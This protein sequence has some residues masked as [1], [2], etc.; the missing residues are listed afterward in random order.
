ML[1]PD[2]PRDCPLC[3]GHEE[4]QFNFFLHCAVVFW[5]VQGFRL[6]GYVMIWE[7]WKARN[8]II[9]INFTKVVVEV[10]D[11]IKGVSWGWILMRLKEPSLFYEWCWDPNDLLMR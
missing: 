2:G 1:H 8:E 3:Q 9:F 10:F 7:L 4:N 5:F 6:I 11:K